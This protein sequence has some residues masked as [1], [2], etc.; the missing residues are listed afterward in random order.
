MPAAAAWHAFVEHLHAWTVA[1]GLLQHTFCA[2]L[3]LL[4]LSAALLLKEV[5]QHLLL[6]DESVT[7][8]NMS[9]DC[10]T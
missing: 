2:Q 7:A 3:P 9:S 6:S 4:A 10:D 5:L 8:N 1:L